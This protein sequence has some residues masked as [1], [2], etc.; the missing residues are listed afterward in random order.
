MPGKTNKDGR[1]D[2]GCNYMTPEELAEFGKNVAPVAFDSSDVK[3]KILNVKYGKLPEHLLDIYLPESG[4][5]PFP[6]VIYVHGGGWRMGSKT[7]SFM[8]G[9]IGLLDHGYAIISVDYRLVPRTT[10]PEFIFDVK[11]AV[12]WAR[13]HASD[14]GFDPDRFAMVGD[15]AGGHITLTMGY[16]AGHPEYAGEAYGWPGVSDGL[17]AICSMYGLSTLED[18][19]TKFYRQSG[20]AR[21]RREAPGA[22]SLY[23]GVFCTKDANLLRLISPI[24]F[25]TKD[26]PPTLLLHGVKDGVVPYQQSTI[27]ADKI[28]KVCGESKVELVLYDDRNHASPEFNTK[29]NSD[30]L[31]AF[32]DK[33][34]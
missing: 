25:V 32:F 18:V 13:A 3:N 30:V 14:Y 19:S 33:W 2:D 21:M 12:R 7:E 34:L 31:A 27:L 17:Q 22:D 15:S 6:L 11:T 1:A 4:D 24:S 20:V 16:T 8:G 29:S 23:S 9:I 26:I 10:Y 28:R 5:G